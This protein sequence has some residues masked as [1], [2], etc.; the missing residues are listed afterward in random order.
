MSLLDLGDL[1]C[2]LDTSCVL[3][4]LV[5]VQRSGNNVGHRTLLCVAELLCFCEVIGIESS[6]DVGNEFGKSTLTESGA[7]GQPALDRH[8]EHGEQQGVDDRHDDTTLEDGSPYVNR[9][10]L[11]LVSEV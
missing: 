4:F 6:L 9:S 10:F 8:G 1:L 7:E 11:G 3:H 5:S 2:L